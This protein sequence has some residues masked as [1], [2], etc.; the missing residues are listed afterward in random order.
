MG[1][2]AI[3]IIAEAGVNHNGSI[4]LAKQL[5][6]A[7]ALAGADY[8]KFQTFSADKVASS[9]APK[10]AYQLSSSSSSNESQL[11]MLRK[12]ELTAAMHEE[13]QSYCLQ[14][15][16]KFLST[17][18][19][20]GSIDLLAK[21]KLDFFKIPSGEITNKPYLEYIAKQAKPVLLS[22][23][24]ATLA[25]VS[26]AVDC[27]VNAGM[28]RTEIS[29]MHCTSEYPAPFEEVN[30]NA[31]LTLKNEFGLK[32]GYSDHTS[33]IEISIAASALGAEFI[34]KHFT[35][36]K[37]MPGPDHKASLDPSE[38]IAWVKAIR[39][40]ES[41]M[42]SSEKKPSTSEIKNRAV[43]RKSIFLHSNLP[44]NHILRANDLEMKR[45]GNGISPMELDLVIGKKLKYDLPAEHQLT[46]SDIY[47][48]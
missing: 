43:V 13:L 10:A 47:E 3:R 44:K 35:L 6:D 37:S 32:V 30:L 31:M 20:L 38:L 4:T 25:E 16:I 21:L 14:K 23:G 28:K 12:L 48:A 9:Q 36:D 24:M 46:Y 42:G 5:I 40:V 41:A 1:S 7:A 15:N 39:N 33:G 8:V 11:D 34:E 17:A 29:L 45:P 26:A 22:T 19:D 18:F 2:T 27:L